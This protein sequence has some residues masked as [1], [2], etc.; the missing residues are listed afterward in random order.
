LH[1]VVCPA[2]AA[3]SRPGTRAT[4][5]FAIAP[6]DAPRA[7]PRDAPHMPQPQSI[8]NRPASAALQAS[9]EA[10]VATRPR[11]P[12]MHRPKPAH[13]APSS[14]CG[15]RGVPGAAPGAC[16]AV[17]ADPMAERLHTPPREQ[18]PPAERYRRAPA[19]GRLGL[20]RQRERPFAM[21]PLPF[22]LPHGKGSAHLPYGRYTP[23]RS[24]CPLPLAVGPLSCGRCRPRPCPLSSGT[25]AMPSLGQ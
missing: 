6:G 25:L 13:H 8:S 19:W 7:G 16:S 10:P 23:K 21:R 18:V 20:R 17:P 22:A 11:R 2:P 9:R 3:R 15:P 14:A 12:P 1:P 5:R 24:L 4:P